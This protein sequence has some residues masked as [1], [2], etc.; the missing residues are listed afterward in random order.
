MDIFL[1]RMNKNIMSSLK[2][3]KSLRIFKKELKNFAKNLLNLKKIFVKHEKSIKF[4]DDI[5]YK[6]ISRYILCIRENFTKKSNT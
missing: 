6:C 5:S 1:E 4:F 2:N 3:N